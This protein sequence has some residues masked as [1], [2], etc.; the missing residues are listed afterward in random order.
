MTTTLKDSQLSLRLP[1]ELKNRMDTYS[2]LTG[3]TRSHV[4][5]EALSS[6]LEWR[7]PQI[8][9]LKAAVIAADEGDFAS[10]DEVQAAMVQHA[11]RTAGQAAKP[12]TTA[13]KARATSA[14]AAK[15]TTRRRPV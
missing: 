9:D 3:R 15:Q 10:E 12:K 6:Y 14:V 2:Q 8:E 1:I 7:I 5:M 4:A 13:A 11:P